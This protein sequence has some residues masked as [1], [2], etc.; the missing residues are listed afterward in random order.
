MLQIAGETLQLENI[1]MNDKNECYKINI[2]QTNL[3]HQ[4]WDYQD[5]CQGDIL[6]LSFGML[7]QSEIIFHIRSFTGCRFGREL[8]SK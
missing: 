7:L 3:T 4:L 2:E 6:E 5:S 8:N 1:S